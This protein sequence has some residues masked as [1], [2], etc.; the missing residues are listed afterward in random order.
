MHYKHYPASPLYCVKALLSRFALIKQLV[1]RDVT[2]RYRGSLFGMLWS[3]LNPLFM[4]A[5]YSFVFTVVF[6][7]KWQ[8]SGDKGEYAVVLFSGLALHAFFAECLARSPS[9][10]TSNPN[11]VKK[12]VFPLEVL[13]PAVVGSA[14][15]HLMVSIGVLLLVHTLIF[16]TVH[17][18]LLLLPVVL[19]PFI[20]LTLG[21]T[22]L[23]AS[24]GVYLR[25]I[26]QII[27]VLTTVL[28]FMSPI[29]FPVTSLPPLA[30]S[31]IYL[32]PL[33]FVV[34]EV[35]QVMIWGELP[36][37]QGW[38]IYSMIALFLSWTGFFW[39]QKTRRGFADVI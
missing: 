13:A 5:I 16:H 20:L 39:F 2:G 11:F 32:N 17:W 36:H 10:I 21:V 4:L 9:A 26:S 18:T 35:R 12:V 34:E 14:L 27:G 8:G 28:L 25:D 22:W 3:F 37:W 6:E 15:F 31:L 7:V 19:A 38:G 1:R 33:S 30:Q 24:L 23:M 29:L